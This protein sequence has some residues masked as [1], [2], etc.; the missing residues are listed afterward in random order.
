[1][2]PR[3]FAIDPAAYG[4][5]TRDELVSYR[6]WDNHFHGFLTNGNPIEQYEHNQFFVE[7]MGIER[8][9]SQDIGGT[10][11][12]P[13]DPYPYDDAILKILE[14]D[15][16]RLSGRTPIDPTFPDKA[17]A[18]IEKWIRDGPCIGIKYPG[19]IKH[20]VRCSHPNND[21][22]MRLA[23]D[24]GVHAYIHTWLKVG[25]NPRLPGGDNLETES[26]PMDVAE[27]A[28]RFPDVPLICGHTGGD[29]ELGV[30]AIRP[31]KNVLIEF[32]GSDPHSGMVDYAIRELGIDRLVWGGHGPS[33]SYAT[34]LGKVLDADIS[35][36]DRM[37]I[38]GGNLRR[39]CA[40]I[41]Q[42][43]GLKLDV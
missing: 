36:R 19:G 20:G 1:M 35:K 12:N 3:E 9:I 11:D 38:F 28:K 14:R 5:P 15:K 10:L 31:H 17:C 29:W 33:R 32:A 18:K 39:I 21:P 26:T 41:F 40:P 42:K 24:L 34:E 6:I 23:R 37:K 16:D 8:S 43:K 2:K 4:L 25:G 27:L 7:R 30:R 22:I 13:Y